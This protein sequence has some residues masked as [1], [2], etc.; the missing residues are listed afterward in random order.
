LEADSLR[1]EPLGRDAEKNTYWYFYGTRLYKEFIVE[2][3]KETNDKKKKQLVKK[4]RKKK[5]FKKKKKMKKYS[6]SESESPT[7]RYVLSQTSD[8]FQC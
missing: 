8:Y 6:S 1:V 2:S 4:K 7:S 3:N 5:K